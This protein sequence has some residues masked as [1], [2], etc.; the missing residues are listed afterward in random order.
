MIETPQGPVFETGAILLWLADRYGGLMPEPASPDR[1]HTVQWL[2]WISNTLNPT[3]RMLFYPDQFTD[4]AI[5]DLRGPTRARL[6][7]KLSLLNDA[8][9]AP[10]LDVDAA[11]AP[12]CYLGPMLRWCALYGGSTDW[13][14]LAR[15]PRLLAFAKR[16]EARPAA[17]RAAVA[18]GLGAT[19]FSAPSPCHPP[20]GS[21]L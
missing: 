4:G 20:E 3:Q 10:W 19:P 5:E 11:S 13:F 17:R 1:A 18:E 15:W 7:D 16:A 21:A 2:F 14:D 8:S 12:S 6:I 9:H